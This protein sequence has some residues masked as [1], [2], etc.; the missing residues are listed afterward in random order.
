MLVCL[1]KSGLSFQSGD[2]P[3]EKILGVAIE[4]GNGELAH[5][6]LQKGVD[7]NTKE[8]CIDICS[9]RKI[10]FLWHT[11]LMNVCGRL[12]HTSLTRFL[13]MAPTLLHWSSRE[14]T[15]IWTDQC[16]LPGCASTS[17]SYDSSL[18]ATTTLILSISPAT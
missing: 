14:P 7:P 6:M 4:G 10:H 12:L 8:L 17:V 13:T 16:F 18:T 3:A 1:L 2:P 11:T 9:T 15:R 5:V